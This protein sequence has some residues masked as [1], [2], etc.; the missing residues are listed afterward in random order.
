M[1][2]QADRVVMDLFEAYYERVYWFARKSVDRATAE[3]VVQEVFVRLMDIPDL[4]TRKVSVSYLL[5][6]ADNLMKRR[7]RRMRQF[8]VFVAR[9]RGRAESG[10]QDRGELGSSPDGPGVLDSAPLSGAEYQALRMIVCEGMS[11]EA[12]AKSLA[13]RTSTINNWKF[14]GIQKLREHTGSN[15][16]V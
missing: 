13:V 14:R 4:P 16:A 12:A 8:E 11:Y 9:D 2:R 15:M 7:H 6:M 3:D 1:S 5:K 10:R